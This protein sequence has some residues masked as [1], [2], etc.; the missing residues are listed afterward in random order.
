MPQSLLAVLQHKACIL[1]F[2][3]HI[4]DGIAQ[5][6]TH[7][8]YSTKFLLSSS[9]KSKVFI[10][11]RRVQY[12]L[13]RPLSSPRCPIALQGAQGWLRKGRSRARAISSTG[14]LPPCDESAKSGR[15]AL[16]PSQAGRAHQPL[17]CT[18]TLY[19]YRCR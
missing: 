10:V 3:C 14:F 17:Q 6:S 16:L 9:K 13:R 11:A 2:I 8:G 19:K 4:K 12:H 1:I 5:E 7:N 15:L 18:S